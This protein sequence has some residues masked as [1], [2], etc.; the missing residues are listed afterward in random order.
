MTRKEVLG[1]AEK[2]VCG[3]RDKSYG[4]PERSF[5]TIAAMWTAYLKQRGM[6]AAI[7]PWD[8][9]WMMVLLKSARAAGNTSY[10]DGC[11]DAAGYAACA[12][13]CMDATPS[14]TVDELPGTGCPHNEWERRRV[15]AQKT[16][17]LYCWQYAAHQKA[18]AKHPGF[19][20]DLGEAL[21]ILAEECGEAIHAFTH[22][23]G[24]ERIQEEVADTAEVAKRI[25]RRFERG[26][27]G[28]D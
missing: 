24:P 25:L 1:A 11:I 16:S 9:A 26:E 17:D 22:K 2:C 21:L 19:T 28:Q 4:G 14:L 7:T 12:G 27:W 13:E 5:E 15:Q 18:V 10:T 20:S 3:D 23:E 8:V 6:A